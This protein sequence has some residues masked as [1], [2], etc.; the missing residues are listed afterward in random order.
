VREAWLELVGAVLLPARPHLER[1][2]REREL[3]LARERRSIT[4]QAQALADCQARI[5]RVR[6]AVLA[7]RDGVVTSEMT[8]LE[9]EWRALSRSDHDGKLMDLW[10]RVAP[11]A[12]ID[13]KLWRDSDPAMQLDAAIALA[14]DA[15]GVVA[16]EAA[17][18]SLRVALAAWGTPVGERI[19]WCSFQRDAD[20]TS[21]LL[22]E[23]LRAAST[24]LSAR[25]LNSVV[26]ERARRLEQEVHVA[27]RLRF[28]DRPML[29]RG[30]SHAAFVD[31]VVHA[32][33]HGRGGLAPA[34][35]FATAPPPLR[36]LA[37]VQGGLAPAARFAT[38]P[39]PLRGLAP[40]ASPDPV[41]SLKALW[42]AGY[43]L[44][45]ID[46]SGVTLEIPPL[47][48]IELSSTS[49]GSTGASR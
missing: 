1:C 19:R 35:R 30:V 20:P 12:W 38:A 21:A 22:A 41:V 10:A 2:L 6:A 48:T 46:S 37:P 49:Q 27:L 43:V 8:S 33:V 5:E 47:S 23:P 28:P 44:T 34:A 14:A 16:A 11:P 42:A 4:R 3:H 45:A 17:V 15:E 29:A 26:V 25:G 18:G 31:V 13:R 40:L 24:A 39:P 9:R 7:A 32:A 36:G